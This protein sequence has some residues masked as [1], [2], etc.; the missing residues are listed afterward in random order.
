[1]ANIWKNDCKN[2]F[3]IKDMSI[4]KY[5][6]ETSLALEYIRYSKIYN[7]IKSLTKYYENIIYYPILLMKFSHENYLFIY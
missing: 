1:M 7:K 4:R 5:C 2:S 3:R 6:F